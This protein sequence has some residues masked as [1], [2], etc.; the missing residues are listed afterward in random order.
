MAARTIGIHDWQSGYPRRPARLVSA[1]RA[2]VRAPVQSAATVT[3]TPTTVAGGDSVSVTFANGPGNRG[4]WW[5]VYLVGALDTRY[6]SWGHLNGQQT[7]PATGL[8][9]ATLSIVM[10][11]VPG[12]MR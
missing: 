7:M 12:R 4:D 3:V 6:L 1:V 2:C 11:L 9:G 8:T 10:P 5:G